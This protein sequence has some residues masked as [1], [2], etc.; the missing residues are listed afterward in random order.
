MKR[1][2]PLS[3]KERSE[4]MSKIRGKNTAPEVAVRSLLSSMGYMYRL[5]ISRLP[6]KPDIVFFGR[7]KLIF[8]HGCFWHLHSCKTYRLPK[9]RIDFWGEKLTKNSSRD[10]Q[11]ISKLRKEKW[12]ILLI[13]ECEIKKMNLGKLR[14]KL[15]T[16]M[17]K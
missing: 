4:R 9:T 10:R 13:W 7:K 17:E 2:D 3:K 14:T 11:N 6:G 16:F 15:T 12:K 5:H 1:I 8:V